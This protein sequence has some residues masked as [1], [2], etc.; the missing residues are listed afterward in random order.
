MESDNGVT[1][2]SGMGASDAAA[3]TG[4]Q[5]ASLS[6]QAA[7]NVPQGTSAPAPQPAANAAPAQAGQGQVGVA[8]P[9]DPGGNAPQAAGAQDQ[10]A[11]AN[12]KP[13]AGPITD[14]AQAN[15]NLEGYTPDAGALAAF[16]ELAVS[17]GLTEAQA[18]GL[19]AWQMDYIASQRQVMADAGK[20]ELSQEW[21]QETERRKEGVRQLIER[22]DQALGNDSFSQAIYA[23]G[24]ACFAG[25]VRGLHA[26][27]NMLAED[28]LQGRASNTVPSRPETAAEGIMDVFRRARARQS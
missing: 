14:W 11:Q 16:G 25:F 2:F 5:T 17:L 27:N 13:V 9:A 18:Q 23:S 7:A 19:A 8:D 6:D 12:G 3:N 28:A 15:I 10:A 22:V 24:A 4:Q 26:M 21:G 1:A 20:A